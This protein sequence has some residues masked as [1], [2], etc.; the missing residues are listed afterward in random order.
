MKIL[1]VDTS[2]MVASVAIL[3]N[4]TL[5]AEYSVNNGKTHSQKLMS[6][7]RGLMEDLGL[8]PRDMDVY[9]A[10]SGPGSFTGLRIGVTTVKAMAYAAEKPVAGVVTLDGLAYNIAPCDFLLCPML[11][12]RNNQV[13]TALY[14]W[15]KN[16]QVKVTEYMGIDIKELARLIKG[17][18]QEA[19]FLGDAVDI[20]RDFLMSELKEKCHFAQGNLN[21]ARA[22]SIGSLAFAKASAGKLEDSFDM[23]PFYLRKS[24]AER[25]LERKS[26]Q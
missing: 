24:Q 26:G 1:A 6:M 9:A 14:K 13:Y 17:R 3:E 11:D 21:M 5:L 15:E 22:S 20:H 7:I 12:A 10:A 23:V 16:N 19:L 2:S 4:T 25:E 18:N 8:K